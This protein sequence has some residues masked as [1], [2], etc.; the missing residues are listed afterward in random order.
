MKKGKES[1]DFLRVC[2]TT[3]YI[4]YKAIEELSFC[5]VAFMQ[6]TDDKNKTKIKLYTQ[7]GVSFSLFSTVFKYVLM[8]PIYYMLVENASIRVMS[9]C[10]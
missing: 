7:K 8:T 4:F 2:E 6:T 1:K 5:I 10:M 9:Y 3:C